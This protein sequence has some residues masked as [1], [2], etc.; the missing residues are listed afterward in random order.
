MVA[1]A[2]LL[3]EPLV[4]SGSRNRRI[5]QGNPG[6]H[7]PLPLARVAY[8]DHPGLAEPIPDDAAVAA[9]GDIRPGEAVRLQYFDSLV[10]RVAL[11]DAAE[12][13]AHAFLRELHRLIL[14][15]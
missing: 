8:P 1:H 13:N 2:V 10:H 14:G 3:E 9:R 7:R 11:G 15:I 12:V 5:S 4:I 6:D